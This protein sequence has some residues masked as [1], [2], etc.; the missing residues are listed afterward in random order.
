MVNFAATTTSGPTSEKECPSPPSLPKD[1]HQISRAG[2]EAVK[3]CHHI[4][5][6]AHLGEGVPLT[7]QLAL[8]EGV[9]HRLLRLRV[10][11]PAM[12]SGPTASG[13]D[14]PRKTSA[15]SMKGHGTACKPRGPAEAAHCS[16]ANP[17][18]SRAAPPHWWRTGTPPAPSHPAVQQHVDCHCGRQ[19]GGQVVVTVFCGLPSKSGA[20]HTTR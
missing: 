5:K 19:R 20:R 18:A 1:A 13:S 12:K 17:T 16:A 15:P 11:K 9:Q 10:P 8:H 6:W 2:T 7:A 3:L 4:N 14:P